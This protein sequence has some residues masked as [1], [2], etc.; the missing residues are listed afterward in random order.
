MLNLIIAAI[1]LVAFIVYLIIKHYK[2]RDSSGPPTGGAISERDE[3]IL[4]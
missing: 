1:V 2:N 4:A 3:V